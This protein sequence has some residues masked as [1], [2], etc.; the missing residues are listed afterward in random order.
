MRILIAALA[1]GLGMAAPAFADD[2]KPLGD[3]ADSL[4][5]ALIQAEL[6]E[7]QVQR[8]IGSFGDMSAA[9]GDDAPQDAAMPDATTMAKLEAIAKAHGFKDFNEY[10]NVAGNISIVMDGVDPAAKTYVGSEALIRRS[11]ADV[12][13]DKQMTAADR[14]AALDDLQTQLKSVTPIKYKGNIDLVL[15]HYA[16]L[17]GG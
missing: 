15:K 12:E 14:Q 3:A 1:L 10:N 5:A 16:E 11:I 6:T 8:Y 4:Y 2:T 13:A 7:D 9:M 17:S